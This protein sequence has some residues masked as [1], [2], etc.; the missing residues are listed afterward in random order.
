[1]T[2]LEPSFRTTDGAA[3]PGLSHATLASPQRHLGA[4][5]WPIALFVAAL[6]ISAIRIGHPPE[7]DELYHVLA[8]RGWLETGR[9][10]I[11]EG[12][13]NRA[14]LFTLLIAAFFRLFGESI[15][16]ARVPS[17]LAYSILVSVFFVW[18]RRRTSPLAAGV[19][20]VL[21]LCSPFIV[22]LA[23]F[24]RFY[25]IQV[26]TFV[27]GVI[28]IQT[29]LSDRPWRPGRFDQAGGRGSSAGRCLLPS[30]S[31]ADRHSRPG[32]VARS[33]TPR[34]LV[35]G[36]LAR[37]ETALAGGV[38]GLVGRGYLHPD[39][40]RC[41]QSHATEVPQCTR[42]PGR[43]RKPILVLPFLARSLLSVAMGRLPVSFS[44]Q[45]CSLS[46]G[47]PALWLDFHCGISRQQLRRLQ[48]HPLSGLRFPFPVRPIWH[49]HR[50]A[51]A[52]PARLDPRHAVAYLLSSRFGPR[53]VRL[54][55]GGSR[56]FAAVRRSGQRRHAEV[57]HLAG[58]HPPAAA[59]TARELAGGRAGAQA[60]ARRF[61]RGG[62]Q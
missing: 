5:A 22:E 28:L 14:G 35:S 52:Q 48:G 60:V 61:G 27:I 59:A 37:R 45:P 1:M 41:R 40:E 24:I 3:S 20:S 33:G 32:L 2:A 9:F 49:G 39:P 21:L 10:A 7:F 42:V 16:V 44:R 62:D 23:T 31:D 43:Y 12:E 50:C 38:L 57:R 8:A 29:T 11:A 56:R 26:T 53:E 36:P 58:R 47:R 15:A 17:V 34:P 46:S 19:A 13:Y 55:A 54:G 18:M 4:I 25:A 6:L 51:V 30:G